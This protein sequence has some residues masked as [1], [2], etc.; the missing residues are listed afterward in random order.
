MTDDHALVRKLLRQIQPHAP[1]HVKLLRAVFAKD[2]PAAVSKTEGPQ[3]RVIFR[4]TNCARV[5]CLRFVRRPVRRVCRYLRRPELTALATVALAAATTLL[6]V[7]T[8]H[9]AAEQAEVMHGQLGVMESAQRPWVKI[10][11]VPG[12]VKFNHESGDA[13]FQYSFRM[14][15]VGSSVAVGVRVDAQVIVPPFDGKV[16]D[17]VAAAQESFCSASIANKAA[18]WEDSRHMGINLFPNESYPADQND[19]FGGSYGGSATVSKAEMIAAEP[20]VPKTSTTTPAKL[21]EY[22]RDP[23]LKGAFAPYLIGCVSYQLGLA[24]GRHQTGFIYDIHR[25]GPANPNVPLFLKVGNDLSPPN[26]VF[27]KWFFG[28]GK[29]D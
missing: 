25:I 7:W 4:M 22:V 20:L 12:A 8:H 19:A 1:I 27:D 9:D 18:E 6:A 13:S 2:Q 11:V 17:G 23:S 5:F 21:L 16:F 14:K 26:I 28:A 15:D 10:D 3:T 29:I 24:S